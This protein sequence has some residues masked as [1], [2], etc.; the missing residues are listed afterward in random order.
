ML[1]GLA[2]AVPVGPAGLYCLEKNT[3][4]GWRTG[5]SSVVGMNLADIFS[6]FLVLVGVGFLS[7]FLDSHGAMLQTIAGCIFLGVGIYTFYTRHRVK[8]EE[9]GKDM[10]YAGVSAFLLA[11]SPAPLLM[12]LLLFPLLGLVD[13]SSR[14][15][16]LA[17]VGAGSLLWGVVVILM[18]GKI[19]ATFSKS[20]Y[21]FKT[22]IA[23]TLVVL[24]L[25]A[26]LTAITPW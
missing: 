25:Y 6:A 2:V 24:G 19:R 22:V 9:Y 16:I 18:G 3:S 13:A 7:D 15:I 4:C 17:G 12:M 20:L 14:W 10:A 11:V 26:T 1:V 5:V 23:L 21:K 8:R